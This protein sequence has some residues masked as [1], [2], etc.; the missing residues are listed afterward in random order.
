MA[1]VTFKLAVVTSLALRATQNV[2]LQGL[3]HSQLSSYI[4]VTVKSKH[5]LSSYLKDQN[6]QN[7]EFD[8]LQERI[9]QQRLS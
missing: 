8:P 1:I 9:I 7:M 3:P 5:R 6:V 4:Y 2:K